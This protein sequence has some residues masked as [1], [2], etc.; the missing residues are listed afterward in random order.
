MTLTRRGFLVLASTSAS[1]AATE[2]GKGRSVPMTALRY[3]DPSTEFPVTRLTDPQFS[4]YFPHSYGHP[5]SRKGNFCIFSSDLSGRMEAYRMDLKT[6]V[7][8]QLTDAAALNPKSPALSTD[9]RTL[10]YLDGNSLQSLAVQNLKSKEIYRVPEGFEPVSGLGLAEDS[11]YAALVEKKA[12][13]YR[14]RLIRVADGV[15]VTLAEAEEEISHPIPRPKRASVLY[16]RPGTVWLSN[17]DAQQ[18]YRLRL[19]EGTNPSALWSPDGHSVLY[20]NVPADSKKL[21]NLR[22]YFPDTNEDKPIAETTQ[23]ACFERNADAS[24]FAGASLSK[25]SPH[26]LLMIRSVRR[27]LTLCEHR[28]SDPS[29]VTPF[30]SPN[31]QHVYFTS[32][33]HG[34]PALYGIPV[35]KLVAETADREEQ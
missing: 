3:A 17:Y 11:L 27:E 15:A 5:I 1:V 26:V 20:L 32:D 12:M 34:K 29:Q 8:K 14:L 23:Y 13:T 6:G 22:E 28:S 2:T 4:S 10:Y 18:N 35:E 21:R 9:E 7:S 24:V 25:A 16:R 33:Q 31:S 19:G 30:F